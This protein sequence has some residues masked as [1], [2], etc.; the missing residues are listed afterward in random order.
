MKNTT[1][2]FTAVMFDLDGTLT[3]SAEGIVRSIRYALAKLGIREDDPERLKRFIGPPLKDSFR[4]IYGIDEDMLD[5]VLAWYRERYIPHGMY[6]NRLYPGILEMLDTLSRRGLRLFIATA[7][8]EP[9]AVNIAAHFGITRYF[10]AIVGSLLDETRTC[11]E[12]VIRHLVATYLAGDTRGLVMVGDHMH[13]MT[14]ALRTGAHAIGVTWG[15]GSRQ[16][17]IDSGAAAIAQTPEELVR[18][19]EAGI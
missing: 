15:Y 3:D 13:D 7:K 16:E 6:E 1:R 17:L 14:G 18:L 2:V 9:M 19:L 11:K 4:E 8:P 12:D 5:Q 10:E